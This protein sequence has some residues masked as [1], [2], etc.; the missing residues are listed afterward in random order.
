MRQRPDAVQRGEGALAPGDRAA[1]IDALAAQHLET[2]LD[3]L[4][5]REAA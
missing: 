2:L 5:L 1:I 3:G 4:M